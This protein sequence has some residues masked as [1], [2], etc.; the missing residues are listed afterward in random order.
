MDKEFNIFKTAKKRKKTRSNADH[1]KQR[2]RKTFTNLLEELVS[3]ECIGGAELLGIELRNF[4]SK[5]FPNKF[6]SCYCKKSTSPS[7]QSLCLRT[8]LPCV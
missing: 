3:Y 7:H 6:S 2:F 1:F 5:S 8:W 4:K